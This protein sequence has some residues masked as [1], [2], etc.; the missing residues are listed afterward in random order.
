MTTCPRCE[1]EITPVTEPFTLGE[2]KWQRIVH[3]C[4]CHSDCWPMDFD[5]LEAGAVYSKPRPVEGASETVNA[6]I[7][8]AAWKEAK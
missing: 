8:R 2:E 1:Q 5:M 7:Q 4:G 3:R 6:I